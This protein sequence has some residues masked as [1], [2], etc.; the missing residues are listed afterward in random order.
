MAQEDVISIHHGAEG[1]EIKLQLHSGGEDEAIE[2]QKPGRS[3]AQIASWLS[4][5]FLITTDVLGPGSAPY[6]APVPA[7]V[8]G[9]LT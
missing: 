6:V 9:I 4:V 1:E 5:F 3:D 8:V 2:I 7:L